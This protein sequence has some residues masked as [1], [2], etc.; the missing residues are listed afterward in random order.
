MRS[1]DS[2]ASF[3]KRNDNSPANLLGCF[4]IELLIYFSSFLQTD[5]GCLNVVNLPVRARKVKILETH[6]IFKNSLHLSIYQSTS[7]SEH[8]GSIVVGVTA[9]R[10]EFQFGVFGWAFCNLSF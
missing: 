3:S 2:S 5:V 7:D 10:Q 9:Q 8:R 6:A 1:K 4:P